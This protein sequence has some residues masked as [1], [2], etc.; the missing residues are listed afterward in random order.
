MI[1]YSGDNKNY[2]NRNVILSLFTLEISS[3]VVITKTI[4]DTA[5]KKST[6]PDVT[7]TVIPK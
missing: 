7:V 1:K 2:K 6:G 5:T 4:T 3:E